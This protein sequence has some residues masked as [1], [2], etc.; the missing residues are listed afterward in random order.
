MKGLSELLLVTYMS[1]V[2]AEFRLIQCRIC[3]MTFYD[4][5]T[6]VT[7]DAKTLVQTLVD[8]F[9]GH[10]IHVAFHVCNDPGCKNMN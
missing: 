1:P 4:R 10:D 3:Q 8:H 6:G 9:K 2:T 5:D 7:I